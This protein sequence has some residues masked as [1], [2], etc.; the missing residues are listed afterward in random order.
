MA[1]K[2]PATPAMVNVVTALVSPA[3]TSVSL[4]STL[5]EPNVLV[6]ISAVSA[7][8]TGASL[9]TVTLM[10]VTAVFDTAEPLVAVT[11]I[12]R[13]TVVGFSVVLSNLISSIASAY[14]AL[15]PVPDSVTVALSAVRVHVIVPMPVAPLSAVEPLTSKRSPTT[16]LVSTMVA[17]AMLA[18]LPSN[19]ELSVSAIE[20]AG[21]FSA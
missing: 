20:T 9:F 7:T 17:P 2:V 15:V 21:P 4:V 8:A 11:L 18:L 14:C 19:I 12:M 13:A 1:V 5:P 6:L 3:S 10:V 16:W